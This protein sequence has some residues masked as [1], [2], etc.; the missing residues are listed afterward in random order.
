M[1]PIPGSRS[2]AHIDENLRAADVTLSA[3]T[4]A[5]IDAALR[6]FAPAGGTLL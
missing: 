2:P 3:D 6:D 4:L 1:V 5:R